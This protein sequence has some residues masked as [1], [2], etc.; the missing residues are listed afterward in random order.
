[1]K[2]NPESLKDVRM[3]GEIVRAIPAQDWEEWVEDIIL[4][5][6]GGTLTT[7]GEEDLIEIIRK[8]IA[9]AIKG[10]RERWRIQFDSVIN[11]HLW[12]DYGFS[13]REVYEEANKLLESM[14]PS[15][16]QKKYEKKK[17]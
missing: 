16:D 12:G 2:P 14:K 4:L 15:Q 7:K 6:R 9:Q 3:E 17:G 13:G 5:V 8:E 11:A 10:E 1:M